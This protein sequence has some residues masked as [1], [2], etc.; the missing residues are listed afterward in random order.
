MTG[1]GLPAGA[2]IL[3]LRHPLCIKS[4]A[5]PAY[6]SVDTRH[7]AAGARSLSPNTLHQG[8]HM[9]N[10]RLSVLAFCFNKISQIFWSCNTRQTEKCGILHFYLERTVCP[11]LEYRIMNTIIQRVVQL[12]VLE[13]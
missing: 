11:L 5:H 6:Y 9:Q 8:A 10:C 2:E 12:I 13:S 1:V 3:F 4:W 7:F